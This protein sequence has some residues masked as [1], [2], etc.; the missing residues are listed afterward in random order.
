MKRFGWIG[1]LK[2]DLVQKYVDLHAHTWQAV[3]DRNRDCHLQNY[4]IFL[5][6]LPGGEHY[7]F[8]YV[9]YT[10]EDFEADMQRMAA[11]PEVQRWWAECK[12]CFESVED[13]PPGEVWAPMEQIFFQE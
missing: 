9:E 12:P 8:S 4:S 7:L 6:R 1:R 10:G 11:D 3:L 2:P 13:L 5:K